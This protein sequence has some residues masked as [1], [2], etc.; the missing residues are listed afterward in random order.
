MLCYDI[1]VKLNITQYFKSGPCVT[2][3]V[4]TY[5]LVVPNLFDSFKLGTL[6]MVLHVYSYMYGIDCGKQVSKYLVCPLLSRTCAC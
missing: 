2:F 5:C 1:T 6:L 3:I 4:I